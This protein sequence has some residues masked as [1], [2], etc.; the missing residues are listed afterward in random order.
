MSALTQYWQ[1]WPTDR[2]IV[3]ATISWQE[4][5]GKTTHNRILGVLDDLKTV[6]MVREGIAVRSA[7]AA[8][9]EAAKS[10]VE[11]SENQN[12][13]LEKIGRLIESRE[14]I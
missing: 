13:A 8:A 2:M 9:L 4:G 10:I 6:I 5:A 7:Q 14:I 11:T 12:D 1:M 3:A